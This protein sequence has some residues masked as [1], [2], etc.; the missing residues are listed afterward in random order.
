LSFAAYIKQHPSLKRLALRMLMPEGEARPRWW[1]RNLLNPFLIKKGK[2]AKIR[3]RTRMDLMPFHAFHL[4]AHSMV[5][6]FACVNNGMGDVLIGDHS[7]IG[8]GCIIIGPVTIGNN[9][10]LAQHIGVSGL[11]HGY[12]DV[13]TPIKDQ[14]CDTGLIRIGDDSWIGTNAVIVA[15]VSIGKHCIVAGGS[16][17][18]KDVPDFTMVGGNP[19]RILKQY[20]P[21][22]EDWEKPPIIRDTPRGNHYD[23]PQP[24]HA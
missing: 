18:T 6:D 9:V 2:R 15:G 13:S 24:H 12:Q 4:G 21:Q 14:P 7:L 8:M 5:E 22:T 17:V 23:H 16:V 20:N 10:I 1:V 3:R 19:A 11:N